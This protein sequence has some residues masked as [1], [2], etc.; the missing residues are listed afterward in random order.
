M[1]FAKLRDFENKQSVGK[2]YIVVTEYNIYLFQYI[3]YP[4]R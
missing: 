4:A 2:F 3:G 1:F